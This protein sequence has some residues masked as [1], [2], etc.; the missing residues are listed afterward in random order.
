MAQALGIGA[1]ELAATGGEDYELCVCVPPGVEVA[2]LTWIGEVTAEGA[3]VEWK[4]APPGA[5]AW[6][7]YEH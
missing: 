3:A 1:A 5:N 2:G 6:R 4:S 7:G